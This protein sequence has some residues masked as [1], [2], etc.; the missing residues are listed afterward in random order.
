MHGLRGIYTFMAI[1]HSKHRLGLVPRI[2]GMTYLLCKITIVYNIN[3]SKST[4]KIS[5]QTPMQHP[6]T[7][8]LCLSGHNFICD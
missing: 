2:H 3:S 8:E 7:Q 1:K 4:C 5:T 6:I